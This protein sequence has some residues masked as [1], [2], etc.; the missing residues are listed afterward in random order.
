MAEVLRAQDL[1]PVPDD[2]TLAPL[3]RARLAKPAAEPTA[4]AGLGAAGPALP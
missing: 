3:A 1:C 4:A 2:L